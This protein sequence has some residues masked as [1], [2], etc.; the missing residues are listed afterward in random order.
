[1]PQRT[2]RFKISQDGLVQE[3]VEGVAGNACQQLTEKLEEALG[4]VQHREPTSESYLNDEIQVETI[5]TEQ[6]L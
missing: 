4:V 3:T 6:F 2:L 5:S 1:M